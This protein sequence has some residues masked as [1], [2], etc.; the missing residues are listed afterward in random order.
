MKRKRIIFV[1][2]IGL[3]ISLL[4]IPSSV[5]DVET[6][7]MTYSDV[8]SVPHR[9]VGLILG[10]PKKLSRGRINPFFR[11]RIEAAVD[12]Y[13][14][15]KVDYLL[16][17]GDNYSRGCVETVSMR[18]DLIREGVPAD[19]IFCDFKGLRTLD[20]V[21]RAKEVFGQNEYMVISQEFQN[22]RAVFIARA[23]GINA[24]GFNAAEVGAT[25]GFL[26]KVRELFARLYAVLDVYVFDSEP[27]FLGGKT[28]IG[29][30][31]VR[32]SNCAQ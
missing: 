28:E 6:D 27:K 5:I 15:G 30:E 13:R 20:S 4:L 14:S 32:E 7:G 16:A 21:V 24:V 18:D 29:A 8:S 23:R 31:N 10:C 26:T 9:R 1:A 12:L 17:S 3:F 19:R 11:N 22:R 25:E 2:V